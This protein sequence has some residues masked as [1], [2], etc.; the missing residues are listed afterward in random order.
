M[1]KKILYIA[2]LFTILVPQITYAE[3]NNENE[4][5]QEQQNEFKIKDFLK[6]TKKYSSDFV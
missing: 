5:L 6:E 1:I 2:I 3:E 4:I